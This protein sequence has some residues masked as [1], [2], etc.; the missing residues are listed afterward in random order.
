MENAQALSAGQ[1]TID[2]VMTEGDTVEEPAADNPSER[3]STPEPSR[4]VVTREIEVEPSIPESDNEDQGHDEQEQEIYDEMEETHSTA[5]IELGDEGPS[6]ISQEARSD[7]REPETS[8]NV[9][10]VNEGWFASLRHLRPPTGPVWSDDPNTP[11]KLW[12]R[13]DQ[14]VKAEVLR[15]GGRYRDVDNRGVIQRSST[16]RSNY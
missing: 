7:V 9:E 13:A 12:A 8:S 5:S 4:P 15:R 1:T 10:G 11:F 3:K 16:R 6:T 2:V 14:N